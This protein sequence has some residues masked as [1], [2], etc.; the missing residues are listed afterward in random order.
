MAA[1][2]GPRALG[3]DAA[4]VHGWVGVVID[5]S[6]FC[7]ALVAPTV[8]ELIVAAE[9]GGGPLASIAV[10]IPIGLVAGPFRAADVAARAFVGPRR[11]S[12][13]PAPHPEVV[14]LVDYDLVNARLVELG[15][16]KVSRQAF[17][18]FERIREVRA[19]AGDPR[20]V[21]AFPEASFA[22][23]GGEDVA[24]SK[25]SWSGSRRRIAL[26]AAA[27]PS[28][29]LPDHPGPAGRVPVDDI[30]D[31]AACAWS[32]LRL[33]DGTAVRLG[34]ENEVDAATGRPIGVWV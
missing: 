4:G 29:R 18:L 26:L 9:A 10:D 19:L 6:G 24:E 32:A 21:E 5:R 20:V 33:A 27:D 3:V 13:F 23:M 31:A 7:D 16:P 25:K 11:S 14:D 17:G 12:V 2:A 34:D 30:L 28:I 22:A 8:Q 1:G 15:M